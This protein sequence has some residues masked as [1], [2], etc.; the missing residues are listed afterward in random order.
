LHGALHIPQAGVAIPDRHILE[1]PDNRIVSVGLPL[2]DLSNER[3]QVQYLSNK[4][5]PTND[6]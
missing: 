2:L 3:C 4:H 5:F 1:A 6:E